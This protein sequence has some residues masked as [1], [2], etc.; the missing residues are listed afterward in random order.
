MRTVLDV[1]TAPLLP[2]ARSTHVWFAPH[3]A[4]LGARIS[5][6]ALS[7]IKQFVGEHLLYMQ[8]TGERF[9]TAWIGRNVIFGE[10]VGQ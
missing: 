4:I 9:A 6:G 5:D 1:K 3:L 8:I 2:I 10:R 7:Q